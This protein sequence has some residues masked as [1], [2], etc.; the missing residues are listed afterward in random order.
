MITPAAD[1]AAARRL[2]GTQTTFTNGMT[3]SLLSAT[4]DLT[5]TVVDG[6]NTPVPFLTLLAREDTTG[7]SFRIP[8][9]A[10]GTFDIPVFAGTWHL[11]ADAHDAAA[12]ELFDTPLTFTVANGVSQNGLQDVVLRAG[13]HLSG[14]RAE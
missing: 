11:Q 7:V 4:A 14:H 8:T 13:L 2:F 5:G 1:D 10:N 6:T 9:A 3:Y 12:Q